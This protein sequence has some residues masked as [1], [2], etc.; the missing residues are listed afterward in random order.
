MA[1]AQHELGGRAA[2]ARLQQIHQVR[3]AVVPR[4]GRHPSHLRQ[5]IRHEVCDNIA[6]CCYL[7]KTLKGFYLRLKKV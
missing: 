6:H 5:G 7:P 2:A 3:A 4:A 1:A